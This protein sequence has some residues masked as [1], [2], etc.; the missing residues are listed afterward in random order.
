[1]ALIQEVTAGQESNLYNTMR[2]ILPLTYRGT[3]PLTLI[4][5]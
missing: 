4:I 1:M 5:K 3:L 2:C